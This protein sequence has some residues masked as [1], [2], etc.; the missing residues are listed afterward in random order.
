MDRTKIRIE[1][2]LVDVLVDFSVDPIIEDRHLHHFL[3][4]GR[5]NK[6]EEKIHME[7]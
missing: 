7:V 5:R 4:Q 2:K 3:I 1:T 6:K